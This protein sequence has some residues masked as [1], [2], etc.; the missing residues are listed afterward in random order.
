MVSVPNQGHW[1]VPRH[2]VS[3]V[4]DV[5]ELGRD[6]IASSWLPGVPAFSTSSAPSSQYGWTRDLIRRIPAVISGPFHVAATLDSPQ[7]LAKWSFDRSHQVQR[8][9]MASR[10]VL[11]GIGTAC[12]DGYIIGIAWSALC[13]R[14]CREHSDAGRSS[15]E[16]GID[17]RY[18]Q[19]G[20]VC[21][22]SPHRFNT[23]TFSSRR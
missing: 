7:D 14:L 9:A 19:L 2:V 22:P 15:I 17:F 23:L 8:G 20:E 4:V 12:G 1:S 10:C 16:G 3:Y 11:Q 5:F 21:S 6:W 18:K 13:S